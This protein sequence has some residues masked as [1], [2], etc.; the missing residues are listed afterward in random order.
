MY[1]LLERDNQ[2]VKD[3]YTNIYQKKFGLVILIRQNL[4]EKN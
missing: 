3:H 2:K 4:R 1:V